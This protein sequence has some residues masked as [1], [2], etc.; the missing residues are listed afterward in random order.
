MQK[1]SVFNFERGVWTVWFISLSWAVV[2]GMGWFML[3]KMQGTVYNTAN[4]EFW[5]N[6]MGN[7]FIFMKWYAI[8]SIAI[9]VFSTVNWHSLRGGEG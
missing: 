3:S 8:A 9:V 5:E 2:V 7:Y 6:I 4:W 1:I